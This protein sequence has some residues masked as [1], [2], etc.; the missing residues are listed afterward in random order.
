MGLEVIR[1]GVAERLRELIEASGLQQK[2]VAIRS[3]VAQSSLSRLMTTDDPDPRISTLLPIAK[4][5]RVSLDS[6]VRDEEPLPQSTLTPYDTNERYQGVI[7]A[8]ER[9]SRHDREQ[10]LALFEWTLRG[11]G[12]S[13]AEE[14]EPAAVEERAPRRAASGMTVRAARDDQETALPTT[15]SRAR[16]RVGSRN[17]PIRR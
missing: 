9:L 10:A 17:E 14:P 15:S 8:L 5:L 13:S 3:G 2:E 1:M 11:I 12:G 6:L 7:Q 4:A 16:Q